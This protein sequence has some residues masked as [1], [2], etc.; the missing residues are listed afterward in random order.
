MMISKKDD[1][2]DEQSEG[3]VFKAD[4]GGYEATGGV[5]W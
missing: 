4:N 1:V 5:G 3:V 2:L